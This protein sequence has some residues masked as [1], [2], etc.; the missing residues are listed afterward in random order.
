M[1]ADLD[2][3][4]RERERFQT[5]AER[6]KDA[7]RMSGASNVS[8]RIRTESRK[9]IGEMKTAHEAAIAAMQ[10]ELELANTTNEELQDRINE[11]VEEVEEPKDE[12]DE[13]A[14]ELRA[15]AGLGGGASAPVAAAPAKGGAEPRAKSQDAAPPVASRANQADDDDFGPASFEEY[16]PESKTTFIRKTIELEKIT[17]RAFPG[18]N[19]LLNYRTELAS[20]LSTASGRYDCKEIAWLRRS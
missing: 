19:Q 4:N 5:I 20:A 18:I 7:D 16:D 11:Q 10:S 2:Y 9:I 13:F 12:V 1:T 17:V 6:T 8:E 3:S 15:F 14:G